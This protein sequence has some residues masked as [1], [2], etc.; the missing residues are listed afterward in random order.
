MANIQLVFSISA[1]RSA[2]YALGVNVGVWS[3]V[4]NLKNTCQ[5]WLSAIR[6]IRKERKHR[7]LSH[8]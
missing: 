6:Q 4:D 7:K 5:I 3:N 8:N 1:I 2:P